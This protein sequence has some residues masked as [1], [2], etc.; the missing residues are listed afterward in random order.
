MLAKLPGF[1][2]KLSEAL[3]PEEVAARIGRINNAV[4]K[5]DNKA[6]GPQVDRVGLM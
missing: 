2:H 6:S 4:T 1:K 5:K 3:L